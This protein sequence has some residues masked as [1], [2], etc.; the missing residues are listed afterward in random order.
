MSLPHFSGSSV[1][2]VRNHDIIMLILVFIE[3]ILDICNADT[4]IISE[5]ALMV[6]T[7]G[8]ANS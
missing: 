7:N 5:V 4:E 6:A 1:N 3:I 2:N 8:C